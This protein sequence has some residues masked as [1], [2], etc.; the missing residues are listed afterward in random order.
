LRTIGRRQMKR[1]RPPNDFVV[2]LALHRIIKPS[3]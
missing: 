3:A 2:L 1:L